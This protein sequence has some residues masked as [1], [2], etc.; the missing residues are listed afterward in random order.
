ML[1]WQ[2]AGEV[3]FNHFEVERSADAKAWAKLKDQAAK[4]SAS[5][6]QALDEKPFVGVN[7]YRLKM[8]DNDGTFSYSKTIAV[9]WD[10][11]RKNTLMLFPNPVKDK[12]YLSGNEDAAGTTVVQIVDISGKIVLQTTI[13]ALRNGLIINNL[14]NGAYFV[15]MT[16]KQVL[17]RKVFVVE[18]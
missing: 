14:A 8:V 13:Q 7:Y 18:R 2:T 4:G 3:R 10:K 5:A 1:T 15:E 16:D 9:E 6:Y 17:E 12:I 11:A